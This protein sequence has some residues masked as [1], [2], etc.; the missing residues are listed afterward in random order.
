MHGLQTQKSPSPSV[1]L[2]HYIGGA[3]FFIVLCFLMLYS[4][5]AFIGHYFHPKLLAITHIAALGWGTMIILGALY[6]L[7]P[8]ILETSLYSETLAKINFAL[9]T[10]GVIC[11]AWSFWNFY[12]GIHIQISAILLL[13]S[14]TLL[15]INI[16]FTARKAPKWTIESD[17]IVTSSV[18]LLFTGLL[19]TMMA[20]NFAYPFL[21]KSHLL[22]L[23][24]HAHM[25]I[26]GWFILLIM[27]VGS[28][29][30]PMF[31][32]AHNLNTKKLSYA[33]YLVNFG[34]IGLSAD[35]FFRDERAVLPL[36]AALIVAGILFFLSFLYE[37]YKKR[38][39][40]QLD[41]GLKHSFMAFMFLFIPILTGI[42][43]SFNTSLND[44]FLLQV[45]MVYGTSIFFGFISSLILGQTF[46]TLPFIVW[47]HKYSKFAGRKKTMLPKDLYSQKLVNAQYILYLFALPTLIIGILFSF[48]LIIKAGAFLLLTTAILYNIN[49]FKII[50]HSF[51]PEK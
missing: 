6:Q 46:K 51:K 49:V 38:L 29:L 27:G 19:G 35:L 17:F 24:I 36:Y 3:L 32:L 11:L 18:W 25:G 7:L 4:S 34:L 42:L 45:Y 16:V 15:L 9:F 41:I 37:A 26:G 22:F 44:K 21:S 20:F 28:K 40:K 23:K 8:V 10:A 5:D 48:P 31:L 33:Y 13:L 43:I 1:V 30:I 39:R 14:F 47:V 2:P 50:V 12:V